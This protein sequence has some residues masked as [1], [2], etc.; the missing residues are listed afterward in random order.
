MRTNAKLA[1][2][3]TLMIAKRA[4]LCSR[5]RSRAIVFDIDID[6]NISVVDHANISMLR[7]IVENVVS[8]EEHSSQD[9]IIAVCIALA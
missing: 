7:T 6:N 3:F 5:Q 2:L 4:N 8:V 9:S 1:N